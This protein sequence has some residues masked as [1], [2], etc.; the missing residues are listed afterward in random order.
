MAEH[1]LNFLRISAT[2]RAISRI[3]RFHDPYVVYLNLSNMNVQT[4]HFIF[5]YEHYPPSFKGLIAMWEGGGNWGNFLLG[6]F[7]SHLSLP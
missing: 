7:L 4:S 2:F 3:W 6:Y 5:V 1:R